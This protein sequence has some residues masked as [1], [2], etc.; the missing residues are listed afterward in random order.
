MYNLSM[1][2][3]IVEDERDLNYALTKALRKEGYATDSAYDGE[4]AL[5]LLKINDYDLVLLDL[6]LPKI[7]GLDVLRRLR[8]DDMKTRVIILSA[9]S[10]VDDRVVGLN[11]GANDY[12]IKPFDFKE[13]EARIRTSLR[14]NYTSI[15][16][17][18]VHGDITLD[19]NTKEVSVKG[20][21]I[22]LTSKEFGLLEYLMVH[23]DRLISN[24]ELFTHVW[25]GY[26]D[27]Y[28]YT[29]TLKYHIHTL[30]KKLAKNTGVEYI[31]NKRNQ[32]Y[33]LR[34]NDE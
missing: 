12:V 18:L 7:D 21:V 24:Y 34:S 28:T 11:L 31:I 19:T 27:D 16:T 3:L 9:R 30:K 8:E 6:N 5:D 10:E 17:K 2:L 13:L 14:M 22:D 15:P 26:V 32:G 4:E 33:R 1:R 23:K 25:D 29:D 20:E